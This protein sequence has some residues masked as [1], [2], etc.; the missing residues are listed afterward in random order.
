MDLV[1]NFPEQ[2]FVMICNKSDYDE[3][4]IKTIK[5]G[6]NIP[7]NLEFHE[8]VPYPEMEKFYKRARFLVNTS[9]YEGFSNTFIEAAINYTPILSLNSD[10][11]EM[12]SMYD[13]G[14]SCS[15][16]IK[17]FHIR[18]RQMLQ[19]VEKT[20]EAGQNAFDYAFKYHRL[21]I[22]VD[23]FDRIFKS[24]NQKSLI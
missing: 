1:K 3:G 11:N 6:S 22:A 9:D 12:L 8:Y 19:D 4:F 23:Q 14:Y 5:N 21:E 16:N 7:D 20:L 13:A 24:I 18:C 15:G 10:P 2:K 17:M